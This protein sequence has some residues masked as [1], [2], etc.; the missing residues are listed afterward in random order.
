VQHRL[1]IRWLP[2]VEGEHSK[3]AHGEG[4]GSSE[5]SGEIWKPLQ[6][7]LVA[8]IRVRCGQFAPSFPFPHHSNANGGRGEDFWGFIF[9]IGC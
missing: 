5:S 4:L 1:Q 6:R 3:S 9:S 2:R 8:R 7:D